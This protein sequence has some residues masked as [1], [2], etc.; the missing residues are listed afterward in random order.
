MFDMRN[1][2]S[3]GGKQMVLIKCQILLITEL[4]KKDNLF[5]TLLFYNVYYC[6]TIC[7]LKLLSLCCK[8]GPILVIEAATVILFM[9]FRKAAFLK[10]H[11]TKW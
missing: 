6:S 8:K 3:S 10:K 5:R 11:L 9:Y 7:S 4:I 1:F 2:V